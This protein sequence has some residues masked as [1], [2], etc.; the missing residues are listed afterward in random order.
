M[1]DDEDV[2]GCTGGFELETELILESLVEGGGVIAVLGISGGEG[3]VEG[4]VVEACE[5][6]LVDDRS[7]DDSHAGHSGQGRG[8]E[9]ERDAAGA[10]ACARVLG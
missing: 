7:R 2:D 5:A 8:K 10:V 6:G 3:P 9:G 4:E 1:V